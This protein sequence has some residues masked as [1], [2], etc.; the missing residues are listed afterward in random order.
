MFLGERFR[1][2]HID[3]TFILWKIDNENYYLREDIHMNIVNENN[4]MCIMGDYDFRIPKDGFPGHEYEM[5][6]LKKSCYSVD[7]RE[8]KLKRILC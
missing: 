3:R 1:Y 4:E 5:D 6:F 2:K 8:K 7:S